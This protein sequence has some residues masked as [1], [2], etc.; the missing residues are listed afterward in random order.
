MQTN[1]FG[2]ST[3]CGKHNSHECVNK[4]KGMYNA[5]AAVIENYVNIS[6]E[7]VDTCMCK[8][9]TIFQH[10]FKSCA[11]VPTDEIDK[12]ESWVVKNVV[13]L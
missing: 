8:D 13:R 2:K 10:Y 4:W 12:R 6:L 1:Q 5:K 3:F 9:F 11:Y 7:T